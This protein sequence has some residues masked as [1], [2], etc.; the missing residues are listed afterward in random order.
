MTELETQQRQAVIAEALTWIGTP[1]HH[2]AEVKGE[3]VDCAK[4]LRAVY[5]ST[6]MIPD[7]K[8]PHYPP[9]WHMHRSDEKYLAYILDYTL[10]AQPPYLPGDVVTYRFG[11]CV[12]HAAIVIDWPKIIH[13]FR[14]AGCV[15][16]DSA[17]QPY[18]LK[19]QCE[20]YR[21]RDWE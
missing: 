5:S 15:V 9:D 1:Y 7:I 2:E 18:L 10:P 12:S 21:H 13:S 4:L 6:G 17:A 19:R 11:R 16:V 20:V 3:G 8:I 14:E